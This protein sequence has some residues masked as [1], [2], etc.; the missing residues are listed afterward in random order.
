M[1]SLAALGSAPGKRYNY[2]WGKSANLSESPCDEDGEAPPGLPSKEALGVPVRGL[3][4]AD[5]LQLLAP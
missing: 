5:G 3:P 2:R 4:V 1:G